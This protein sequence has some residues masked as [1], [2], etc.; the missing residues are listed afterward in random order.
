M[1]CR[2]KAENIVIMLSRFAHSGQA[3]KTTCSVDRT[4]YQL[5][6][7]LTLSGKRKHL[8]H[9]WKRRISTSPSSDRSLWNLVPHAV[10]EVPP[11]SV[12]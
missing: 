6:F 1:Q 11:E 12:L 5:W 3:A 10:G 2:C 9:H 7:F 8:T 4:E